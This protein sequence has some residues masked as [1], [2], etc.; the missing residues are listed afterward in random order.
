MLALD[1]FDPIEDRKAGGEPCGPWILRGER[2]ASSRSCSPPA[3]HG[4][5]TGTKDHNPSES[6]RAARKKIVLLVFE[7]MLKVW[8]RFLL[9]FG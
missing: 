3:Y 1:G 9:C 8:F 5:Q 6:L 2:S 4:M 7:S